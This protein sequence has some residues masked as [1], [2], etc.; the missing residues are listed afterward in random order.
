MIAVVADH[1]L[2][3]H[4][5]VLAGARRLGSAGLVD[6]G[7]LVSV[8]E[9]DEP[10]TVA[11]QVQEDPAV[12]VQVV[13]FGRR[14]RVREPDASRIVLDDFRV[15]A[16]IVAPPAVRRRPVRL[17][18]FGG[19]LPGQPAVAVR[20][21][22]RLEEEVVAEGEPQGQLVVIRARVNPERERRLAVHR[23]A[24]PR[25]RDVA[26]KKVVRRVLLVDEDHVLDLATR[27]PRLVRNRIAIVVMSELAVVV[28]AHAIG[29]A[30]VRVHARGVRVKLP[31]GRRGDDV[32]G[33]QH[34][35]LGRAA[36]P[37]RIRTGAAATGV[38]DVQT[39]GRPR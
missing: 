6:H 29:E 33:P 4:V 31:L 23:H 32:H 22:R 20:G 14:I 10:L 37:H 21:H 13:R 38:G 9:V 17:F 7:E 12:L 26:K 2:H 35:E 28:V 19:V 39:I 11:A 8:P 34:A 24:S 15:V 30:V 1:L 27:P 16:R 5:D 36:L 25:L 3:G 18:G